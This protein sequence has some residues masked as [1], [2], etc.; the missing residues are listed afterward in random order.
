[1]R[2]FILA[3]I[4]AAFCLARAFGQDSST[5]LCLIPTPKKIIR[6]QGTFTFTPD[7]RISDNGL[8]NTGLKDFLILLE[9]EMDISPVVSDRI[10]RRGIEPVK[11]GD[12]ESLKS[13]LRRNN[14]DPEFQPGDEGYVLKVDNDLIRIIA[15]SEA[16]V[17][18]GMQTLSQLIKTARVDHDIPSLVIYDYPDISI[19]GWQDDISRG[20]IPTLDFL[21]KEVKTLAAYKLNAMTLYTENVFKLKKHPSLAPPDGLTQEEIAEL[22]EFA[23]GY[24]VQLIG[25]FQSF[26]HM[27]KIL[28]NEG[29]RHLAENGHI[30]SPAKEE[31]YQFLGEVYSEIIPAYSSPYFNINC[32]E[33]FGLG[34]GASK[35]MA[36]SIGIEGIY[37]YHINRLNA[38]IKPYG[39]QI[40]M[41]GDIA[42]NPKITALLPKDI[43]V[44]SWGY[45]DA[46]S[47]EYA[48]RPFSEQ[49]LNFWVA[50]GVSCWSNIFPNLEVARINIFNYIRDGYHLGA[51]GVL[52][53]TWD[54]DGLDFFENNWYPLIWGAEV[55]WR[56]DRRSLVPD[57]TVENKEP[58]GRPFRKSVQAFDKSFDR[59]FFGNS[60]RSLT[61]WINTFSGLHQG[62]V[63]D[64]ERNG[65][66]FEPVMLF[67]PEY[68]N[69]DQLNLNYRILRTIDSLE[70]QLPGLEADVKWNKP[71]LEYLKFALAQV[72]F[73]VEKN[74]F[75]VELYRYLNGLPGTRNPDHL[76]M[77]LKWLIRSAKDLKS[78]YEVLWKYE[79]RD[80]WLDKNMAAFDRLIED[81]ENIRGT[82]IMT[83]SDEVGPRGRSVKMRSVFDKLPVYY[84]L[85]GTEPKLSSRKYKKPVYLTAK[86]TIK[87]RV[88]ADGKRY[89]VLTD[90]LIMH[91]AIGKL[92]KLNSKWSDYHPA[93]AAGG[94]YGLID[95]R[96]GDVKDIRSG[97]WQGFSGQDINIELDLGKTER[98]SEFSMGF[99]QHTFSWVILPRQVDIYTS[100]N[101]INYKKYTTIT[102]NI[103]ADF[104]D[105]VKHVFSTKLEG[106]KARYLKIVGVYYGPLP[107]FHASKG[108][109]SMMFADEII[110]K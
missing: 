81:L 75:R 8:Q 76:K 36:D 17:F 80:W 65:R 83:V 16:G 47:F 108:N 93:Y 37:G 41:W 82:T 24:H 53:T 19:R 84:T 95:G 86:T 54:D 6:M 68:I 97:R 35:E 13:I 78:G 9:E 89:P 94:K 26:G 46:P 3:V 12:S 14:L 79:S 45:H 43:T 90:S 87:A 48:I 72:R 110:L 34:E 23:A 104:P 100:T 71:S 101:G 85:D 11:A 96:T 91:K 29:Y 55:S 10:R 62:K 98:L 15:M 106:L 58:S 107:E 57:D 33:T 69:P 109:P 52:N 39:K 42:A 67:Y 32:D 5:E 21:K 31:S 44:I 7:L 66:F 22:S 28:N 56:S 2:K 4:L 30:I 20:P 60:K 64:I 73:S 18:Y 88:I 59:L 61:N 99:Y 27:D 103:P 1:M 40:L 51:T 38:L 25:N 77:T 105:P 50:P 70:V 92:L 49:G 74:L 63:R 102:H